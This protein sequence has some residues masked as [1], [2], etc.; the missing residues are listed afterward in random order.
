MVLQPRHYAGGLEGNA[1]EA[2]R[3]QNEKRAESAAEDRRAQA[4]VDTR[5]IHLAREARAR[6]DERAEA[7]GTL[8][9]EGARA[10]A[11]AAR[12][13]TSAKYYEQRT[14]PGSLGSTVAER[15]VRRP[16]RSFSQEVRAESALYETGR[17]YDRKVAGAKRT[18]D[19][20]SV[21][22]AQAGQHMR[23]CFE[24]RPPM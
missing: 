13:A 16:R 12:G 23:A 7:R 15:A 20:A 10:S 1:H 19:L 11:R 14:T 22:V 24:Q 5:A 8:D 18:Q 9:L 6:I 2:I 17:A 4:R 3:A 21:V